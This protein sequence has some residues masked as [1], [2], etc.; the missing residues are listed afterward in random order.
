MESV[1][2]F[3]SM[4]RTRVTPQLKKLKHCYQGSVAFKQF[5]TTVIYRKPTV[6]ILP[7]SS[8]VGRQIDDEF[9]VR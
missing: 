3:Q 5:H 9:W 4:N 2:N 7:L 6:F 8:L 1:L